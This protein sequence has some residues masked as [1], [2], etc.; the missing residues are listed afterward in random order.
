L[1]ALPLSDRAKDHVERFVE[2]AIGQV[3]DAFRSDPANRTH[4][5][6]RCFKR[7]LLLLDA[8][9]DRQFHRVEFTVNDEH[10]KMG[11][12]VVVYVDHQ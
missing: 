1:D 3:D 11:V 7:H 10:A 4:P 9:G 8:W 2:Y 12:L 5:D 6:T